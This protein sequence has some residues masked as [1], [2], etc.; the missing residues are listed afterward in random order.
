MIMYLIMIA[1][2]D[3][4]I[5]WLTDWF[6]DWLIDMIAG[7]DETAR[8]QQLGWGAGYPGAPVLSANGLDENRRAR[9]ATALQAESG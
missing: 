8:L 5:D 9:G 3:W 6:L 2:I 4:L 7:T 1:L